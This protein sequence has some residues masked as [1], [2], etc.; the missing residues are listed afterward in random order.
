M[1]KATIIKLVAA[2]GVLIILLI[3]LFRDW[4]R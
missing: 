4:H 2:L 1:K 3:F